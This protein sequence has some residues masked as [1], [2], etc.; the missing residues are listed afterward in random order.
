ME[1]FIRSVLTFLSDLGYFG[2][3]IGLML[4]VIPSEIVLSYGGY[5]VSQGKINF[6]GA[7]I[8]GTIGGTIAQLFL[9][10]MG[11]Y[12]GRPF[13][14]KYGKY[15]LI[16]KKEIDKAEEW[17]NRY[18]VGVIFTARFIPVVRH[19]ISIPAG[20]ARM[21]VVK[22]IMYT[23][24]AV[25]PWSILFVYLGMQLGARW[26]QIDEFAKP[27]IQPII[28]IAV[29]GTVIYLLMSLRKRKKSSRFSS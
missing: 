25:I 15:L 4:E 21:S 13:L 28:W 24:L 11:Y 10:W 22:F 6:A 16:R 3:A 18:G 5:L 23:T 17:F 26:V 20:I 19:A 9:Y 7:I 27:F 2:I 12:G 29:A 1:E 14:E 8:A